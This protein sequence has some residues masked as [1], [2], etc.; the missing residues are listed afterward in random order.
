MRSVVLGLVIVAIVILAVGL[1]SAGARVDVDYLV[2]TWHQA[3]L[4]ALS[5]I[6]AG[7]VLICG[8]AA[9]VAARLS[10]AADGRALRDELERTYVRLRQAESAA[11]PAAAV[12]D[13][14]DAPLVTPPA[15]SDSPIVVAP[16]ASGSLGPR[17]VG[18]DD[19]DVG[20][21]PRGGGGDGS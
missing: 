6:V 18:G 11:G 12:D 5:A 13:A 21:G 15:G 17:S 20:D 19:A 7:L 4:P 9:A 1:A 16:A 2:G 10:E 3:S 14:R 8:L